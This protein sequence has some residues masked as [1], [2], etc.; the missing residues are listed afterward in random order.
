MEGTVK[1]RNK[2]LQST[3]TENPTAN[4]EDEEKT[5]QNLRS[6][7]KYYFNRFRYYHY[8]IAEKVDTMIG[9]VCLAII[10]IYFFLMGWGTQLSRQDDETMGMMGMDDE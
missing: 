8:C 2:A 3:D 1:R 10:K 4:Q 6:T 5:Q 7:L 9:V